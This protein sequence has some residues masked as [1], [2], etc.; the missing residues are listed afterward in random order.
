MLP[1][2]LPSAAALCVL[3]AVASLPAGE[4]AYSRGYSDPCAVHLRAHASDWQTGLSYAT[5]TLD[6]ARLHYR[7]SAGTVRLTLP[8]G[9]AGAYVPYEAAVDAFCAAEG[10]T[11]VRHGGEFF[12]VHAAP[13][14][15]ECAGT[16]P[17]AR[18]RRRRL[19]HPPPRGLP[20]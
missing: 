17:R 5:F 16:P 7:C 19:P 15:R 12:L 4:A 11:A 8:M 9:G 1:R 14:A 18:P 10:F 13:P 3:L 6:G 2:L 20:F